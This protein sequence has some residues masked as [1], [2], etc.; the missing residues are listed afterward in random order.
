MLQTRLNVA[1]HKYDAAVANLQTAYTFAYQVQGQTVIQDLVAT[2]MAYLVNREARTLITSPDSPNLYWA[3]ATI[4]HPLVNIRRGMDSEHCWLYWTFPVLR[5]VENAHLMDEQ[6]LELAEKKL[7][8][9][10]VHVTRE[11]ILAWAKAH[12]A[13]AKEYALAA[14]I[15]SERVE[16]MP[17]LQVVAFQQMHDYEYW[18]DAMTRWMFLPFP[19]AYPESKRWQKDFAAAHPEGEPSLA[20]QLLPLVPR[21]LFMIAK[22]DQEIAALQCIEAI[23]MYAAENGRLPKRLS[24]I[25]Q[26][27]APDDPLTGKPFA[28]T[29]DGQ[30][31]TL[32][33]PQPAGEEER[34]HSRYELTLVENKANSPAKGAAK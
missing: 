14:G 9:L 11:Q 34:Y 5:D 15:P 18:S 7:A 26:V 31:A 30:T 1:E 19:Q 25:T 6:W 32:D 33:C 16:K 21:S 13:S 27:P 20:R 22:V 23:R 24:D 3:L 4:P 10:D 12:F 29:L 2:A 17:M 8:V 28:Y